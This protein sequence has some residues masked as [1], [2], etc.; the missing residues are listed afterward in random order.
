MTENVNDN[1]HYIL[2]SLTFSANNF[3]TVKKRNGRNGAPEEKL[4]V[5]G[6]LAP[7]TNFMISVFSNLCRY[8]R[9]RRGIQ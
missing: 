1:I 7:L 4:S 9:A 5:T 8:K 6:F 3:T 2:F